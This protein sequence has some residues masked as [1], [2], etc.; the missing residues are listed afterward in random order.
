M[1]KARELGMME[2]IEG[3]NSQHQDCQCAM[4]A[5]LR[6][7]TETAFPGE[8]LSLLLRLIHHPRRQRLVSSA[9]EREPS[10]SSLL[11]LWQTETSAPCAWLTWTWS[12]GN[13]ANNWAWLAG[14]IDAYTLPPNR[15]AKIDAF[16]N[17]FVNEWYVLGE[18]VNKLT[19]VNWHHS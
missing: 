11:P 14:N 13:D 18:I 2:I 15:K 19:N 12:S 10:S 3:L 9:E 7:A 6:S 16:C 4:H 5:A 1:K 17:F 8:I